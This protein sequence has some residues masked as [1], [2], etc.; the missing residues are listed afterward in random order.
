MKKRMSQIRA[1]WLL[2]SPSFSHR[3]VRN[4]PVT[5]A[6]SPFLCWP[7]DSAQPQKTL[8]GTK[9][10]SVCSFPVLSLYR[11]LL[12]RL[13]RPQ[14]TPEGLWL[15]TGLAVSRQVKEMLLMSDISVFPFVVCRFATGVVSIFVFGGI[16]KCPSQLAV[17]IW[18]ERCRLIPGCPVYAMEN[19]ELKSIQP[20]AISA[21]TPKRV[22]LH[23]ARIHP[24]SLRSQ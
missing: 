15:I 13:K 21:D 10:V 4:R 9:A 11:Q 23:P 18:P 24:E 17:R 5:T 12:A 6:W 22:Q 16:L 7:R 3:S 14:H 1:S 20:F 8:H 2:D 19:G